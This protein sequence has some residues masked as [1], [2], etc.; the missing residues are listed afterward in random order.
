MKSTKPDGVEGIVTS[1]LQGRPGPN[2]QI[3]SCSAET[4]ARKALET[5]LQREKDITNRMEE[6]KC[7]VEKARQE[8]AD[9]EQRIK[10]EEAKAHKDKMER[11]ERAAERKQRAAENADM[12]NN[13]GG[14]ITKI[15]TDQKAE[16]DRTNKRLQESI[17]KQNSA[18]EKAEEA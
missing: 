5:A 1:S 16:Q 6:E 13:I 18:I 10:D 15:V 11:E 4:A 9:R 17:E 3:N 14:V 2:K 8:K 7:A 12:L